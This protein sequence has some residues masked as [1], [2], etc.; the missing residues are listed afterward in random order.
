MPRLSRFPANRFLGQ[1]AEMLVYDCDDPQ[2]F[3]ALEEL[4]RL[5]D[6]TSLN[7][8]QAFAPDSLA[9]ARNRGFE[10]LPTST[11]DDL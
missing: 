8:L 4:V 1:R 2:E 7:L 10:P 3:D 11:A 9:E 6:L 5:G